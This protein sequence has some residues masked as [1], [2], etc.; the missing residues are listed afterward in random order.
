MSCWSKIATAGL[1]A[2]LT[3][4]SADAVTSALTHAWADGP[5]LRAYRHAPNTTSRKSWAAGDA[6]SRGVRLA[7]MATQ[8]H[9]QALPSVLSAP[10]WGFADVLMSG[11]QPKLGRQLGCYVME[12]ILFKVS[13]PA[14]FHAQTAVECALRL[15][16]QVRGRIDEIARIDIRTQESALRI[17]SKDGELR[18]DA[19]RDHCLQYMV[20]VALLEGDL[21]AEHYADAYA[22]RPEID[23][24]RVLMS[25]SEEPRYSSD[26]LNPSRRS[27][28]NAISVGFADGGSTET[29]EVEYPLGHRRRRE[30]AKP[31]LLDKFRTAARDRLGAT[32]T[33]Q[34]Q[35][36]FTDADKLVA[37][38]VDQLID[39]IN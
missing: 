22:A 4:D 25:V 15:H 12:N 20:A 9:M 37:M 33:D 21:R 13:H 35:A 16:E 30:E 39:L 10:R 24:L 7:L 23:R 17:I 28:A 32:R 34:L 11:V 5:S 14:E 31:K 8:A 18:N 27:I 2:K 1:A 36:A 6:T 26:Y 3:S 38:T 19:D 29:V